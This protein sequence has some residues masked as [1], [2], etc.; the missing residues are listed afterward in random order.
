M[1][2]A[3]HLQ[4]LYKRYARR[5]AVRDLSLRVP[6]GAI[7]GILG[8]N[9]AGKSTTL[10]MV[11][12]IIGSDAGTIEVL[13]EPPAVHGVLR[14][15]GY[16]PEERGLYRRMSVL[17]VIVFFGRLKGLARADARRRAAIWLERL[18][19]GD[20]RHARVETLSKGM[21]QKVQFITTVLHDPDLL[22]LDEPHSG[23]DPVNQEV[24][25]ET[26]LGARGAGRTI[27]LS[28]HNMEQAEALCDSV[29]IIAD[30]EKVLDGSV[31]EVRR[32]HRGRRYRLRIDPTLSASALPALRQLLQRAGTAFVCSDDEA[33]W[34]LELAPGGARELLGAIAGLELELESFERVTPTLHE[35]FLQHAGETARRVPRDEVPDA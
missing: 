10:R 1:S 33:H 35:I 5:Q 15:V 24:L 32:A 8:P 14:R 11:M 3:L 4:H 6:V 12:N 20:W 2:D 19:L 23:L 27:V 21:Q 16:L 7:Y 9:G 28:T 26:I 13:G 18:G 17:D 22:I 31:A 30:G 29:C 25:R 34:E